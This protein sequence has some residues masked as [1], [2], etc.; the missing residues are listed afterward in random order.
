VVVQN[1]G[2]IALHQFGSYDLFANAGTPPGRRWLI[3]GPAEYELPVLSWQLEALAFF[4][5]VVKGIDNG[6][7]RQARV[8]YWRD[9]AEDWQSGDAFPPSDSARH[10]FY[11]DG[12][13]LVRSIPSETAAEWLSIP[14]GTAV[15][16]G[17]E[18][19]TPQLLRFAWTVDRD[20]ELVGPVT[21][22]L[23]YS[24][25]EIDSYVV[26]RLD[27]VR[28]AGER[29]CLA[30]GH[31]RPARRS[32]IEGEGSPA[33][34]VLDTRGLAPL[35]PNVAVDLRFSL[36]PAAALVRA[37]ERLELSIASRTDLLALRVRDGFIAPDLP[38]PPF[39]ALNTLHF[40]AGTF[41]EWTARHA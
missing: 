37:G 38:V 8:R 21:L 7:D 28:S 31:L 36:T 1:R 6:Y 23:R 10:R 5:H 24:C 19:V 17:I 15:L 39:F 13:A 34:I 40:G 14:R 2:L 27:R 22:S 4:D 30:M 12:D 41:I 35:V 29:S 3:I 18:R 26:A 20:L 16:P 11:L 32:V 25:N 33:E 9:G